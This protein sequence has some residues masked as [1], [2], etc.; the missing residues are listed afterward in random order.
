MAK[1]GKGQR[2]C[3]F[4]KALQALCTYLQAGIPTHVWEPTQRRFQRVR[5]CGVDRCDGIAVFV[6]TPPGPNILFRMSLKLH[7]FFPGE[8]SMQR[9]S[10]IPYIPPSTATVQI[11]LPLSVATSSEASGSSIQPEIRNRLL[12]AAPSAAT[13][14]GSRHGHGDDPRQG[15]LVQSSVAR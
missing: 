14:L 7:A 11:L 10:A 13:N 8:P 1:L 2:S 15:T 5:F 9:L 3:M 6:L 12:R 4:I